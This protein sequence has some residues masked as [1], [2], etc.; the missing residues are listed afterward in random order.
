M[1]LADLNI[2][3]KAQVLEAVYKSTASSVA[4]L[5]LLESFMIGVLFVCVPLGTYLLR[6]RSRSFLRAPFIAMLWLTFTG[7]ITHWSFS[8]EQLEATFSGRTLDIS[9]SYLD[10]SNSVA[11]SSDS[12]DHGVINSYIGY[13]HA[14][15]VLLTLVTETVLFGFASSLFVSTGYATFR[16]ILP[17]RRSGYALIIPI[18]ASLMYTL[19]LM[20]WALYLWFFIAQAFP[21]PALAGLLSP[22]LLELNVAFLALLSMN[23][24]MSDAI[25][26]W[27]MCVVWDKSR[28]VLAFSAAL[29][30]TALGVNVAN[31]VR[32]ATVNLGIDNGIAANGKASKINLTSYG[33]NVIGLAAAFVSLGSNASATLLVGI[34]FWLHRRQFPKHYHYDNRRTLIERVM[35]LLVESGVGYTAIWLLYCVSFF[36]PI[37]SHAIF[38]DSPSSAP[39]RLTAVDHLDAA[40]AQI[41][42]CYPLVVF[43]LVALEKIHHSHGAQASREGIEQ[44]KN[45]VLPAVTIT[46]EI[47]IERSM[48]VTQSPGT[49]C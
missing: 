11:S 30:V 15:Q 49:H 19:S 17:Q 38:G 18:L 48:M 34:K 42:S 44:P 27:R 23:A 47:D 13:G 46:F 39:V 43:L 45:T 4:P 37:T 12:R 1:S 29:L 14:W 25:V 5:L 16:K 7:M 31:I 24:V 33:G 36:Q 35:E 2:T 22:I 32:S 26:L 20:H 6:A 21:A 40:M 9:L 10:L 41:T 28:P 8:L 3:Q